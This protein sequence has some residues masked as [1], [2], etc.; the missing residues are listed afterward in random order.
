MNEKKYINENFSYLK[1][2][3]I[4]QSGET[5][6]FLQVNYYN[7]FLVP[8]RSYHFNCYPGFLIFPFSLLPS[9]LWVIILYVKVSYS[10][11]LNVA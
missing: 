5:S 6:M 1:Q 2:L 9:A 10:F 11:T 4:M 8:L 7:E 3:I